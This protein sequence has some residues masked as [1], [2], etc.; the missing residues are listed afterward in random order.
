M[1]L[2]GPLVTCQELTSSQKGVVARLCLFGMYT[3]LTGMEPF[4][5]ILISDGK[6]F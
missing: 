6:T 2:P 5:N 3:E 4:I 1:F